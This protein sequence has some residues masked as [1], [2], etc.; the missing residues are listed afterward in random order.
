MV[1]PAYDC[2]SFQAKYEDPK[3]AQII[4]PAALDSELATRMQAM[5]WRAAVALQ[6]TAMAR[7][8][9]FLSHEGKIYVNEVN[10]IPGFTQISMYSKLWQADGV[11]MKELLEHLLEDARAQFKLRLA[12]RVS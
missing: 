12:Q 8:D 11:S 9:F 5:A 7:V 6:C 1:A 10:S 4:V 3:G 2:Y